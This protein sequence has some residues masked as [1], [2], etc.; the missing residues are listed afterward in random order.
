M[1][2]ILGGSGFRCRQGSTKYGIGP[3]PGF[4]FGTVQTDERGVYFGL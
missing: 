3:E 4:V 1:N 2:D